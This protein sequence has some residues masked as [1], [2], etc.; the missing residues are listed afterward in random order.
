MGV[1]WCAGLGEVGELEG[2]VD[3][4]M[5]VVLRVSQTSSQALNDIAG[6]VLSA[7]LFELTTPRLRL[8]TVP[9]AALP[10]RPGIAAWLP[11]AGCAAAVPPHWRAPPAS[12]HTCARALARRAATEAYAAVEALKSS[13]RLDS[14]EPAAR[15]ALHRALVLA[16][17]VAEGLLAAAEPLLLSAAAAAERAAEDRQLTVSM[18]PPG[19][20]W[21]E[22]LSYDEALDLAMLVLE[23]ASESD[24]TNATVAL[25]LIEVRPLSQHRSHSTAHAHARMAVCPEVQLAPQYTAHSIPDAACGA[26]DPSDGPFY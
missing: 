1:L 9:H 8:D 7:A 12:A 10:E 18:P 4:L 19:D 14:A 23:N 24:T 20:E 17:A 6:S 3:G 11:S 22:C 2:H 16:F 21:K 13:D 15:Q 26:G 5:D 25:S